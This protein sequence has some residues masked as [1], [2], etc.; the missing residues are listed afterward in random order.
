VSIPLTPHCPH[1]DVAPPALATLM[2]AHGLDGPI[3]T[4]RLDT[5][6]CGPI[7]ISST[8]PL[9]NSDAPSFLLATFCIE[10]WYYTEALLCVSEVLGVCVCVGVCVH[11]VV[12]LLRVFNTSDDSDLDYSMR[13]FPSLQ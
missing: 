7:I 2:I 3:P 6:N 1:G 13:F 4:I 10:S 12:H 9:I 8:V 11:G 5:L